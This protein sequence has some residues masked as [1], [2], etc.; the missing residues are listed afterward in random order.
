M[1]RG[2]QTHVSFYVKDLGQAVQQWAKL[3][4]ILDPDVVK[5]PPVIFES[6]E[7]ELLTRTATL[8]NPNGLEFQ[9]VSTKCFADDP[10]FVDYLDHIHF[11]TNDLDGKFDELR[12]AGFRINPNTLLDAEE[13]TVVTSGEGVLPGAEWTRWFIV[14]MPGPIG[15]EVASPYRPKDGV[16]HP[17][18]NW[19]RDEKYGAEA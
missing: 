16:W 3:L 14:P 1:P 9:F 12:E 15:V 13:A 19:C 10:D 2:L 6:G 5:Q 7:G 8:V 18:E 11:A 17:I 4:A